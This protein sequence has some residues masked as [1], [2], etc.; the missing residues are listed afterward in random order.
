[1]RVVIFGAGA[2]GSL[3]GAYLDRAGHSVLLVGRADHVAAVRAHGLKVTGRLEGTFRVDAAVDLAP[4][5]APD[6]VLVTVKTFDLERAARTLGRAVRVGT[7]TLLLQNGLGAEETARRALASEGW[8]D[9]HGALVR[10]VNSLPAT[11]VG[12]GEVRAAGEGEVVLPAPCGPAADAVDVFAR[13]LGGAGIRVRTA[14]DLPREVWRKAVLNAAVNP[15]TAVREVVNGRLLD[16]PYREEADGL[17]L[18]AAAV[19]RAEGTSLS[20]AEARAD[21]E[22]VLRATAENRSSMLQDLERGRPTEIDA[23][24]GE[25][26]RIGRTHHLEL[27]FTE[28]AIALIRA[29]VDERRAGRTEP[30]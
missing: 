9:P 27:P 8:P 13:L 15:V 25:I 29:R 10:A 2:V 23:I 3:L 18:E 28:R 1:M 22:R 21:L 24:S 11:W 20:D 16:S 7:P 26:V 17:L 5:P 14:D 12:P 19:A 30:S 4:G 6:A